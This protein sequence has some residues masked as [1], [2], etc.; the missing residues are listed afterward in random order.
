MI[1][2]LKGVNI[3]SARQIIL[4]FMREKA[5]KPM[6][7]EELMKVFDIPKSD[8]KSFQRLLEQMERDGEVYHTKSNLYGVPERMDL[9]V[10]HLQGHQ[11]GFGFVIPED[12]E[13]EDVFISS[14]NLNGAM[15]N[16]KVIARINKKSGGKK[17]EG[18]IIRILERANTTVVGNFERSTHF[19]F[20]V[21]D[22]RRVSS[23]IFVPK[24]EFNGAKEG[25]KVIVEIT[26]WPEKRRNPE[27]KI[28]RV[29]GHA[30]DPGVD[31]AGIIY[32]HDLPEDFPAEVLAQ[33]NA[34]PM[35]IPA[36]EIARRRDIRKWR[37]F[38]IDGEDAKDFDDAVSIERIGERMVRLG[39]HIADV[40]YYVREGTPLDQEALVRGTSIYLVDRV[41]PMLP[42]RLSNGICSLVPHED[43]LTMSCVMDI[44]LIEGNVQSYEIFESVIN[45]NERL[46]YTKVRQML[47]DK[48]EELRQ[49]YSHIIGD[50][51]LMEQLCWSLRNMRMRR[52]AIDFNFGESKVKLDS[53]G[54]VTDIVKVERSVA[55][56]MIEEFMIKANEVVSEDMY[57]K[58][59][60]FIYRVHDKPDT[61]K[62][63][64]FNE[65]IH[66]F[67]YHIKG[68]QNEIHPRQLQEIIEKATGTMEEHVISTVLLRSM[69]QA[70]Y[71]TIP[72]GHF[73][74][75]NDFY[76]HFTSPIRR[77]PDLQI[78]RII[79]EVLI[80][81]TLSAKRIEQLEEHLVYVSEHSSVQER[82]AMDAERESID[83]KKVE[84]MVDKVGM[85]FDGLI[86]GVLSFGF[87]VELPNSVE[88]L[89]RVSRLADDYYH[90]HEDHYALI[91]E[92]TGKTYR[93]GDKVRVEVVR[94][95]LDEREIDFVVVG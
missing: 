26:R 63:V 15:H 71:G 57:W 39:V 53:N 68:I 16:D 24:E 36:E 55:E 19:G 74:L 41:I 40:T 47:V 22:D 9:V 70:K 35:D 32:Q 27:G 59:I 60:P 80:N 52:G 28:V 77:Y 7:A 75:A 62:L 3:T 10:G 73:G 95:N 45:S 25:Q 65:F 30:G 42:Q 46:T 17:V 33:A 54:K 83:L 69:K 20:V 38:T 76:S 23:D 66:N 31:I 48:D 87:F 91:G 92:R 2:M 4:D 94:A 84:Y 89:V 58:Q 29:L 93:L 88:G 1:T 50:L 61:Q 85:Q 14:E 8:I 78:H 72:I 6:T 13:R 44:D 51:E 12:I 18:E 11:R 82:K 86:S 37:T 90:F 67:G 64:D 81:G 34:I 21:P 49:Q 5:Y 79:R 43:R 56:M